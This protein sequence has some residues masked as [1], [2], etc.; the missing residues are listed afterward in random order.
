MS[1]PVE[2]VLISE[3]F[4]DKKFN[5]RGDIAISECAGLARDMT[6]HGQIHPIMVQPYSDPDKPQLKWQIVEGF[7]RYYA[8]RINNWQTIK[9]TL[10]EPLDPNVAADIN[11][12][13]NLHRK[14]LTFAQEARGLIKFGIGQVDDG[15]ISRRLNASRSWVQM[16]R[17]FL[18]LPSL[19]QR[20]IENGIIPQSQIS[21]L[22]KMPTD[23]DRYEAVRAYKDAKYRGKKAKIQSKE[24]KIR[25][26]H[27]KRARDRKDC[28]D[29]QTYVRE[30]FRMH[31]EINEITAYLRAFAWCA[32]IITD[33][34][35]YCDLR[36]VAERN[37]VYYEIPKEVYDIL[38][39]P[40]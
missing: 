25:A 35:L 9:A 14:D 24:T 4:A 20:E 38:K 33:T 15:D 17:E 7:R 36:E 27:Q 6:T 31:G 2:D 39:S 37:G 1:R 34:E 19:I 5:C 26:P 10:S 40:V 22:Y 28:L 23:E 29:M 11:Y 13:E 12:I 8:A 3:I 18:A 30:S 21:E 32:G 16:R